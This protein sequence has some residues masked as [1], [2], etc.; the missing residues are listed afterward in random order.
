MFFIY[1]I[2]GCFNKCHPDKLITDVCLLLDNVRTNF[3][4]QFEI[5]EFLKP[6]A[7]ST[8]YDYGSVMHYKTTVSE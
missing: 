2:N 3:L 4:D 8:E 6:G 5:I 1:H 7:K